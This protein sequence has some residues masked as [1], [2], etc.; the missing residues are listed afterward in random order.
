MNWTHTRDIR[1]WFSKD[2]EAFAKDHG[3]SYN[4]TFETIYT[5]LFALWSC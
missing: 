5:T 3:Y 2:I 1:D 4:R